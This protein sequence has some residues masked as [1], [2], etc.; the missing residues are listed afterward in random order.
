M[1]LPSLVRLPLTLTTNV[2]SGVAKLALRQ[3]H[4]GG[5][6]QSPAP[7]PTEERTP[8]PEASAPA[9]NPTAGQAP[10]TREPRAQAQ[11]ERTVGRRSHERKEPSPEP[12]QGTSAAEAGSRRASAPKT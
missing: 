1:A 8:S 6:S 2:A 3:L 7:A 10:P 11:G 12:A 5:Q 9:E 4:R